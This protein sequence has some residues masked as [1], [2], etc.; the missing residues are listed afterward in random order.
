MLLPQG[1]P[2]ASGSAAAPKQDLARMIHVFARGLVAWVVF[3]IWGRR[4]KR[5]L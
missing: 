1:A 3:W 2:G 5:L 4:V